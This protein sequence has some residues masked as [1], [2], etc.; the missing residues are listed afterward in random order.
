MPR[1]FRHYY[2]FSLE[3][4][5]GTEY[6]AISMTRTGNRLTTADVSEWDG[7]DEMEYSI[8]NYNH[9]ANGAMTFD[10]MSGISGTVFS[11]N[12]AGLLH[13]ITDEESGEG[14][15]YV[16]LSDG[17]K[18]KRDGDVDSPRY[19]R[20]SFVYKDVSISV[21]TGYDEGDYD[22]YDFEGLESIAHSEGRFVATDWTTTGVPTLSDRHFV[23]D[24]VGST[25]TVIDVARA[26]VA[27]NLPTLNAALV[28]QDAYLA[29]GDRLSASAMT[30]KT[31]TDNRYRFNGKEREDWAG[32]PYI[33]YGARMYNPVI[34]SWLSPD[35]LADKYTSTSPYVFC[36][37]DPVNYVDKD[38]KKPRI[39]SQAKGLGHVFVTT[40]EGKDTKVYS[41]GRYGKLYKS[42]GMTSGRFTPRGEGVLYIKTGE[43]A[44]EFLSTVLSEGCFS[45]FEI[46]NANDQATDKYYQELFD[47][48]SPVSD[49]S[50][51]A[52]YDEDARV[53]DTYNLLTNNCVIV[54]ENG[55]NAEGLLVDSYEY[56]PS[57][58][59]IDLKMQSLTN[60]NIIVIKDPVKFVENLLKMFSG[61]EK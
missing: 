31:D 58:F 55:I 30:L 38:G 28:E 22:T 41:Y 17:T 23:R 24:L 3:R 20:G 43:S 13:A 2:S 61:I 45:V 19:Y 25:V 5:N 27:S 44:R 35:P 56:A 60:E 1:Y 37:G 42:S 47:S 33:D 7:D 16:W 29:Y 48:G 54:S 6:A 57:N 40:G 46:A 53:I 4:L 10:S 39:Y 50:K 15:T 12:A 21:P 49:P 18:V 11:W 14:A 8:Y 34:G 59:C 36:A 32:F 26:A 51:E 52:F 9:N